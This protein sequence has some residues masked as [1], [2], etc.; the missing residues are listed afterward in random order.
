MAGTA[1]EGGNVKAVCPGID[2]SASMLYI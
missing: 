1:G 2:A